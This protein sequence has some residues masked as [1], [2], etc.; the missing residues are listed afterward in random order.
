MNN[1]G[2]FTEIYNTEGKVKVAIAQTD[3]TLLC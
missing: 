2:L 1:T 3:L